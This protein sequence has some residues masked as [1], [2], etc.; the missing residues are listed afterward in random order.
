MRLTVFCIILLVFSGCQDESDPSKMSVERYVDLLKAGKYDYWELPS[1]TSRD[2]PAL[3]SYRNDVQPITDFPVNPI[4]SSVTN[5]C[6]LGMYILWTIESIRAQA[7]ESEFLVGTFPSQNPVVKNRE[8]L[9]YIEPNPQVQKEVADSYF[10]W[11]E[12]N[13]MRNF[14]E[15]HKTDPLEATGYRWH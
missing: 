8:T 6:T 4:S 2:I 7:M 11:W 15:F 13:G 1:F 12:S 10:Q 3:L 5:G 9:E 14:S